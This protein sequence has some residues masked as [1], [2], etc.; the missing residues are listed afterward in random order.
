MTKEERQEIED[1]MKFT[2]QF[3]KGIDKAKE[4]L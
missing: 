2:G 4:I 3:E 1:S